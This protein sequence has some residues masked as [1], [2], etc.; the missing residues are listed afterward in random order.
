MTKSTTRVLSRNWIKCPDSSETLRWLVRPGWDHLGR[1]ASFCF[2]TSKRQ[3]LVRRPDAQANWA[4]EPASL[5]DCPYLTSPRFLEKWRLPFLSLSSNSVLTT[6]FAT[7]LCP[8]SRFSL[9]PPATSPTVY[10]PRPW[11]T[12]WYWLKKSVRV[13]R[14]RTCWWKTK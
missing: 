8:F 7:G 14:F 6:H 10:L 1:A 4:S 2:A 11:L 9:S 12:R 3:H 5:L 13:G